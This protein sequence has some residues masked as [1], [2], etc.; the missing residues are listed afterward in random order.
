MLGITQI[1]R[2]NYWIFRWNENGRAVVIKFITL[3]GEGCLI[4]FSLCLIQM[5][6]LF[7]FS[8]F[9]VVDGCTGIA[10]GESEFNIFSAIFTFVAYCS[11]SFMLEQITVCKGLCAH[12]AITLCIN[13]KANRFE[14]HSTWTIRIPLNC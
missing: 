7:I 10:S 13:N 1:A 11:V 9:G 14:P 8:R 12:H 2:P 3:I 6:W 4:R 5:I